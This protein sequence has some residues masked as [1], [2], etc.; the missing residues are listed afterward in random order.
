MAT[1]SLPSRHWIVTLVGGR[2]SASAAVAGPVVVRSLLLRTLESTAARR[3]LP[4]PPPASRWPRDFEA[5]RGISTATR[6][7]LSLLPLPAPLHREPGPG[8]APQKPLA[9]AASRGAAPVASATDEPQPAADVCENK[10]VRATQPQPQ[11]LISGGDERGLCPSLIASRCG[12]I[13]IASHA[14]L[15]TIFGG[16]DRRGRRVDASARRYHGT[17]SFR[18]PLLL[19]YIAAGGCCSLWLGNALCRTHWTFG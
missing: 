16:V 7:I 6:P 14:G 15:R 2:G 1:Y 10:T 3:L 17:Q 11:Q 13:A 18:C 12:A 19:A 4:P 9:A 5:K 8:P